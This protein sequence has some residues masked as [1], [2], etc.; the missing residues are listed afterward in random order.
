[1]QNLRAEVA[2]VLEALTEEQVIM[3][4]A[5]ARC[6]RDGAVPALPS[7]EELLEEPA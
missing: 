4:L 3:V 1:M 7:L 6:V 2:D 5:Y